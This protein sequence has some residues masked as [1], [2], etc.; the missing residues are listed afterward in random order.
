MNRS[1]FKQPSAYLPLVMS[2]AALSLVLVHAARY[3]VVHE[4]DEGTSAHIFQL[5]MVAEVPLVAF[6]ALRWLPEAPRPALRVLVSQALAIVA[7]FTA[8]YWLT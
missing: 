5:L 4:V 2:L 7:A 3:G 1:L 6:F 8:V